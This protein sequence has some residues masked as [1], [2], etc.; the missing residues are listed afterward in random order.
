V[1]L[2]EQDRLTGCF[3]YWPARIFRALILRAARFLT[4][5]HSRRNVGT[6]SLEARRLILLEQCHEGGTESVSEPEPR[7]AVQVLPGLNT[8]V[9][10][11]KNMKL[12]PS[13]HFRGTNVHQKYSWTLLTLGFR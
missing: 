10:Q 8:A 5:R 12:E 11:T 1:R 4:N 6:D 7:D 9:E 3:L 13:L 2:D